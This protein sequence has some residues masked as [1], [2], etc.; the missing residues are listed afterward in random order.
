MNTKILQDM[1]NLLTENKEGFADD[2]RQI[3]ITSLKKM[4]Y[5]T[6]D[7]PRIAKRPYILSVKHS[8]DN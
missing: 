8:L 1:E 7:H 3:G 4:S 2:E 5:D 6:G